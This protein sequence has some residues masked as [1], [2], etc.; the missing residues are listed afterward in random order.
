MVVLNF[1]IIYLNLLLF[2]NACFP[3]PTVEPGPTIMCDPTTCPDPMV[4]PAMLGPIMTDSTSCDTTRTVEC[5]MPGMMRIQYNGDTS[6]T[7]GPGPLIL[8]CDETTMQYTFEGMS[9]MP[10]QLTG[11]VVCVA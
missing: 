7:Y 6:V 11:G 9:S 3:T 1:I 5:T 10:E 2:C 8:T 4:A